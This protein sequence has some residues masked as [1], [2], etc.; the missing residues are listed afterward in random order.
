MN[1]PKSSIGIFSAGTSLQSGPESSSLVPK[2]IF[3]NGDT[4][5]K[6]KL[7]SKKCQTIP[8]SLSE[9]IDDLE[10]TLV[11]FTM[12]PGTKR[13]LLPLRQLIM[14]KESLDIIVAAAIWTIV[15]FS[16]HY[17]LLLRTIEAYL[18]RM[19][20]ENGDPWKS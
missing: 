9:A 7:Q 2:F 10:T 14:N 11:R 12:S 20:I 6:S 3:E 18:T 4:R 5:L 17:V 8:E 13:K 16:F 19:E 1:F 15:S